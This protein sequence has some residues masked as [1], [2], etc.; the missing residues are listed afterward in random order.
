MAATVPNTTQNAPNEIP[1]IASVLNELAV[2]QDEKAHDVI[3]IQLL[4]AG[5]PNIIGMFTGVIY[6]TIISI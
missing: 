6:I 2:G 1:T 3:V 4:T 5:N